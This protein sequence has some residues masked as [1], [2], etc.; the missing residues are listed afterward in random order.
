MLKGRD[1][2]TFSNVFSTVIVELRASNGVICENSVF[3]QHT[4]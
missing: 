1:G 3:C 4:F 2:F